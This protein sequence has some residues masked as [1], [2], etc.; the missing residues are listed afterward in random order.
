MRELL[1]NRNFVLFLSGRF[2]TNIG[3]SIYW[4]AAVWL[5][6]ELTGSTVFTG[7][8][9]FLSRAPTAVRFLYGPLVDRVRLKAVF[10][11]V[12]VVSGVVLLAIPIAAVL[13]ALSVW[14]VLG[15]VAVVSSVNQLSPPAFHKAIPLIVEEEN[16]PA[17][18]STF[19][20][21]G[22]GLNAVFNGVGGVVIAAGGAV[23]LLTFD[24]VTFAGGAALFALLSIPAASGDE[25]AGGESA[26]GDSESDDGAAS[27]SESDDATD[28]SGSSTTETSVTSEYLAEIGQ[29]FRY[30]RGSLA[31]R[32]SVLKSVINF[33]YGTVIAVLPAFADAL[34]DAATFGLLMGAISAGSLVGALAGSALEDL[35][36]G[37]MLVGGYFLTGVCIASMVALPGTLLTVVAALLSAI[38][39]G[40]YTVLSTSMMQTVVDDQLL[41]RVM[42]TVQSIDDAM[43]PV[44]SVVGGVAATVFSPDVMIY[45][46]AGLYLASSAYCLTPEIRSLPRITEMREETLSLG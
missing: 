13:D 4:I 43:V 31:L 23:A 44:G 11:G 32:L 3:D 6:F 15:V 26:A 19:S 40:V 8:A 37:T 30:L 1:N 42:S 35:S 2:V 5:V 34:G 33:G 12:Q 18:N 38:P 24:A 20:V 41:G 7:I 36:Y 27:D 46:L 17:A 29:G 14:V 9:A 28:G 22:Q 21:V 16:V 25:N 10:V 45:S 39:M